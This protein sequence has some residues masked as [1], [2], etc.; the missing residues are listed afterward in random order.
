VVPLFVAT[1]AGAASRRSLGTAVFGGMLAATLL[2]I[3][4]VP[5]QYYVVET[6]AERRGKRTHGT[7]ERERE[8]VEATD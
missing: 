5:V 6:L 8:A 4:F 1:G 7:A 2:A 3:F